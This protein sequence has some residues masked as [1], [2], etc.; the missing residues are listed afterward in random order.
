MC[1]V[2]GISRAAYYKHIHRK[3]SRYEKENKLL[4]KAILEEYTAS[5]RC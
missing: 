2:L 3:P 5:K 1:K 4:D